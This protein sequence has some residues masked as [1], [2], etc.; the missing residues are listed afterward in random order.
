MTGI[1]D[2]GR[3]EP[4][5]GPRPALDVPPTVHADWKPAADRP[6]PIALLEEQATTRIPDLVPGPLRPDGGLAVHVLPRRGAA[7]GG[8]P[9]ADPDERA[10]GPARRR[11]APRP[12]SGCSPRPSGTSSSTSTTSTRRIPG[13]GSGT[14]KR[15][16]GQ[17]RR[18]GARRGLRC[19]PV[20]ATRST[21]PSAR[22]AT[23][24]AE[25]AAMRA[26][27]VYYARV[28]ATDIAAYV[29][30]RARPYLATTVKSAAHHDALH[31][32]PEADRGRRGR[33]SSDRRPSAD[34]HHIRPRSPR[35]SQ[36][37]RP[38]RLSRAR[39]RRTVAILLDRYQLVDWRAS[40]SSASAASAWRAFAALFEGGD[41]DDPLFLQ[42]KEAEASVLERFL[43]PSPY[44]SHGERVVA[45]Q[46]RLQAASDVMLGWAVG[47]RGSPPLRPPA[48]GPE[49][50]RG[51]RGD[52]VRRPRD[53]GGA[54]R[55]GPGPRPRAD[56][57]ASVARRLSRRRTTRSTTRWPSSR[58]PTR[59]R[60]SGTTPR[61][62]PRSS[63]DVS[64]PNPGFS[65][66]T[67]SG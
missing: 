24:M 57:R 33:A 25:Y 50:E 32:L 36:R 56:R 6:D 27:D 67:R 16:A 61:S 13:P 22:I 28:D 37:R 11:R 52:D 15:L 35:R 30:K 49:G 51:H 4:R 31:E 45:G 23:R 29:D 66:F 62:S 41:E 7:D 12:T 8:R 55:L 54:V 21:R 47:P 18:R 38:A 60:P 2:V 40:R 14:C 10:P 59:T 53:V 65:D 17:P 58:S 43:G 26:I 5:P 44:A 46:R 63:P 19:P 64:P 39:S 3:S 42:V 1:A 48:P 9:G 20:A 34:D